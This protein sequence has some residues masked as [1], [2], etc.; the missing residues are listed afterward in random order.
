MQPTD[1]A[2]AE[3]MRSSTP[4]TYR[5]LEQLVPAMAA[6]ARYRGK[7][8]LFGRGAQHKALAEVEAGLKSTLQ[9]MVRDRLIE[10]HQDAET[11]R[12]RLIAAIRD[13]ASAHQEQ[14]AAFAIADEYLEDNAGHALRRI[15]E[16]MK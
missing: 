6:S 16:F 15:R 2:W 1:P 10:R 11:C 3:M 12:Q 14:D 5:A 9:A 4:N 13:F 7:S 8:F